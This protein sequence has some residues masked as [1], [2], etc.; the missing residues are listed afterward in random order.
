MIFRYTIYFVVYCLTFTWGA[1]LKDV[2]YSIKQNGV[3]INIDYDVPINDDAI[4]GWKSD[5]GWVYLTLLG[6]R[7][8]RNK[9]TNKN[10]KGVVKKIV[11]DDFDESTQLAVLINKPILGYDII[12]S[13]GT[14][15]T[16]VFIH[17]EMKK[18][19]VAYL[20]EYIEKEGTSVFNTAKSSGFPKYNTNFKKAFDQA[21]KELG[22]NA[23]FEFHGKLYTTNHPGEKSAI[24]SSILE[25][26]LISSKD[27]IESNNDIGLLDNQ[28]EGI[29]IDS[30]SGEI[31]TEVTIDTSKN[32]INKNVNNI[33]DQKSDSI[34]DELIQEDDGWFSG[35][36]PSNK[37]IK[38]PFKTKIKEKDKFIIKNNEPIIVE[39]TSPTKK[40]KFWNNIFPKLG[41]RALR[42]DKIEEV[43]VSK[44]KV[45]EKDLT[46]LQNKF[47]PPKVQN[48]E[49]KLTDEDYKILSQTQLSDTNNV[50]IK[51]PSDNVKSD[52]DYLDN[53]F[54]QEKYIPSQNE[55]LISDT[56]GFMYFSG[57]PTQSPDTNTVEAWF[58]NENIIP[59]D[60][61]PK[62]LQK[63]Y[64]PSQNENLISDTSGFMY[65]SGSPTQSPDTNTV[66]AWFTN[67]NIISNEYDPKFLQK[68]YIPPSSES[69]V[70]ELPSDVNAIQADPQIPEFTAPF[71]LDD[72]YKIKYKNKTKINRPIREVEDP[73]EPNEKEENTWLSFFP[74]QPD[75][76]KKK[77][78]WDNAKEKELPKFL[79]R[80]AESLDYSSN[81]TKDYS[82]RTQ[83]PQNRPKS[84][85]PRYSD[86]GFRYYNQGG[87]KVEANLSGIPIY[88]DGKYVGDTPLNR[89]I[90]VEPGWHQVS[91]FSP[92][93]TRLAS[94]KGLQFVGYDSIVQNNEMYGS[95]TV[96]AEPGKLETVT[97]KFNQMG[98]TP[99]KLREIQG[100]MSMG[101][102][103]FTLLIGIISW[104]M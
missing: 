95:T 86:P 13:K 2:S 87:I 48:R 41:S 88:I 58:T 73:F 68:Q 28:N 42:K 75:S 47:V 20:K 7:A 45:D 76:I 33:A 31:F 25:N 81:E 61:D 89:P 24:P 15:G 99:K 69:I 22:P 50:V 104:A 21:R 37:K 17:T 6:V 60:F 36:F 23:I 74:L 19:E 94:Q 67:E 101:I 59:S 91:G 80:E 97:L 18:S 39:S 62:F 85:P 44:I 54:L 26:D 78:N 64:I 53:K 16:I 49:I 10:F 5:R 12:N 70:F 14:P 9:S 32:Q 93:Y 8:P 66:E 46:D 52:L 43:E 56:S 34:S 29:Y 79:K 35:L 82:W 3:M 98:D 77:L 11:I 63:Q 96:Y 90:E 27:E 72:R 4:I 51:I 92:V 40:F 84:F 102:P 55:N 65:F 83:L 30:T 38:S 71:I 57:S 100:G 1:K 103:M